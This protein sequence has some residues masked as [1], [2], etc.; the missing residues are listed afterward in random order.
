MTA[1]QNTV[2]RFE[3]WPGPMEGVGRPEFVRAVGALGLTDRW[4]TPFLRL[5][6]ELPAPGKLRRCGEE[7]FRSGLPVTLQLMSDDPLLAGAAAA[8]LLELTPAVGINLNLGCPSARVVK[9]R[10]GGG[11]LRDPRRA[12][13]F[14][15]TVAAALPPGKLSVKLRAGF[16][17]PGDMAELLPQ[18]AES[19]AV[20]RIFFHFRTVSELYRPLPPAEREERF[21]RA[22]RLAAPVPVILNGDIAD[23]A[24][25]EALIASVGGAGVMIARPWM[26]D[27]YLLRRFRG[28]APDPES[29]RE[30]FFAELRRQGVRDGALIEMAR[31]LWGADAPRFR[32]LLSEESLS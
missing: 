9:N 13:E 22:V 31:L 4:M 12:A 18:L 3:V 16:T 24:E 17:D 1:M 2:P 25:A 14:C 10:A 15:R 23:V 30:R 29:G 19:G 5:S 7:Y 27:P 11:L 21:A 26:R 6:R 20:S 32:E 28:P 8:K